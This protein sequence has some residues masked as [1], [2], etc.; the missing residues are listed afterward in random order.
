[1]TDWGSIERRLRERLGIRPA[2]G[3]HV[4]RVA[5]AGRDAVRRLGAVGLLVL[6]TE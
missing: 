2:R 3:H 4:P 6:A 5:A 1:M